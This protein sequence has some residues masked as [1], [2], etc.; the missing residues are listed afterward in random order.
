MHFSLLQMQRA[1]LNARPE[2][3]ELGLSIANEFAKVD[4]RILPPPSL[5]YKQVSDCLF[6]VVVFFCLFFSFMKYKL[7]LYKMAF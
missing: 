1:N 2:V 5:T 7:Y 4:G 3:Q 6:V